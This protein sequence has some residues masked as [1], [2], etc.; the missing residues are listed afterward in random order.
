MVSEK[1]NGHVGSPEP[2]T[3]L[4]HCRGEEVHW[5][6]YSAMIAML[7][8]NVQLK[9]KV[10]LRIGP[11][12]RIVADGFRAFHKVAEPGMWFRAPEIGMVVCRVSAHIEPCTV[13]SE[14]AMK[15][16]EARAEEAVDPPSNLRIALP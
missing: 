6:S 5:V 2:M 13:L 14:E 1:K 12:L 4:A 11:M 7:E 16:V 15:R 9:A 3:Y 8:K 10:D